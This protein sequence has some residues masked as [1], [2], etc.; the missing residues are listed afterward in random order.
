[1]QVLWG[2]MA[3]SILFRVVLVSLFSFQVSFPIVSRFHCRTFRFCQISCASLKK[4]T[5]VYLQSKNTL[6][7]L[8]LTPFVD[9]LAILA[10][11]SGIDFLRKKAM[12]MFFDSLEKIKDWGYFVTWSIFAWRV[13]D[14]SCCCFYLTYCYSWFG[15][16]DSR[17]ESGSILTRDSSKVCL[18]SSS[19]GSVV[20]PIAAFRKRSLEV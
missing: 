7:I 17:G 10:F 5:T 13:F 20:A 11:D 14:C 6:E 4:P 8:M 16:S 9:L 2:L 1:M 3:R 12:T 19:L 18:Y 15:W